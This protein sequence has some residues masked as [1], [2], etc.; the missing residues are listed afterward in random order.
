MNDD[1]ARQFW[2][3]HLAV[4]FDGIERNNVA[5]AGMA[6]AQTSGTSAEGDGYRIVN[7]VLDIRRACLDEEA[8]IDGALR[9]EVE[10]NAAMD[11]MGFRALVLRAALA[12]ERCV[13][14]LNAPGS[15]AATHQLSGLV[16]EL[17][18]VR[19]DMENLV[20]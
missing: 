15:D 12:A 3:D 8:A 13:A 1:D 20:P 16:A 11:L 10:P 14:E 9:N 5:I 19:P 18:Q 2:L 6:R 4:F 7:A 17:L